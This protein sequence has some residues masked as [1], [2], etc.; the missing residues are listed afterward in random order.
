MGNVRPSRMGGG[1]TTNVH[2][3]AAFLQDS[4]GDICEAGAPN[5][6]HCLGNATP[7]VKSLGVH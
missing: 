5:Y 7:Q 1:S 3:D 4:T 2:V 6:R